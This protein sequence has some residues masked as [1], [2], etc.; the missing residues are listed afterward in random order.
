[1]GTLYERSEALIV[2]LI[3]AAEAMKAAMEVLKPE[4]LKRRAEIKVSGKVVLGTVAGDIHDIGKNIVAALL[5]AAG[6]EV[7][8]LG[9]DVPAEKFI[10]KAKEV[11]A[12][13]IGASALLTTT[14]L[15]QK[16]I[17]EAIKRTGLNVKY[18]VGGAAVS[19]E[20]AEEIG[21]AYA[22]DAT[23]AVE[24]IKNLVQQRRRGL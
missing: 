11:D 18:I 2:E 13:V 12:D 7:Y 15:V 24:V 16:E 10:E 21:A 19:P 20:W 8:D 14:M 17:A 6:F 22:P 1:V 23:T 9:V 4:I 3:A 5:T